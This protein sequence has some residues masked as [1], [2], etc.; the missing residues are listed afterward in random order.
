MRDDQVLIFTHVPRTGG[1]TLIWNVEPCFSRR[2]VL[3]FHSGDGLD[4]LLAIPESERA[5]TR[6]V[7]GH[8]PY[9][10]H[11]Y[12]PL[13]PIY[14]VLLRDPIERL[15]SL[16]DFIQQRVPESPAYGMTLEQFI[17]FNLE[18]SIDNRQTRLLAGNFHEGE[19]TQAML[20][21]AIHNL[22]HHY[23]GAGL[24]ERFDESFALFTAVIGW[25]PKG[26]IRR[27]A[28]PA[29]TPRSAIPASTLRRV[30]AINGFDC[31]LLPAARARFEALL[32]QYEIE[33]HH[34]AMRALHHPL[35]QGAAL[36]RRVV[37]KLDQA[38]R[39]SPQWWD[40]P[41]P[42]GTPWKP[43]RQVDH[44]NQSAGRLAAA[45]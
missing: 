34:P 26:T 7:T 28:A 4:K 30:E 13:K 19:V 45:K 27:N 41:P 14:F 2:S 24:T 44:P 15:L 22:H 29:R 43:V 38:A 35:Y 8:I 23:A 20:D 37:R 9:G 11:A 6:F 1:V 31:E 3:Y 5:R 16:Y 33:A 25:R 42:P 18:N 21:Q 39:R 32:A 12:L 40:V 10:I 17:D 36:A